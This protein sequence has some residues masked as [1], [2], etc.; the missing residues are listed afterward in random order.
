[1]TPVASHS[2]CTDRGLTEHKEDVQDGHKGVAPE[3]GEHAVVEQLYVYQLSVL[4]QLIIAG[5]VEPLPARP[6]SWGG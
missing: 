2:E 3:T 6:Y 1:M 5:L 4:V